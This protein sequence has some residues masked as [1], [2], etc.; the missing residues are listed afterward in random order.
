MS[1]W[2]IT[3]AEGPFKGIVRYVL[4]QTQEN[5]LRALKKDLEDKYFHIYGTITFN[6]G[7]FHIQ[8]IVKIEDI[9][10]AAYVLDSVMK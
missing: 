6:Q 2:R 4:A 8:S 10:D 1:V 9:G 3:L 5:A 7:Y